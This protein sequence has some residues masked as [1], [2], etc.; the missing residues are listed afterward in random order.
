V[1]VFK[2]QMLFRFT[3]PSSTART[4]K[5]ARRLDKNLRVATHYRVGTIT[6]IV[7]PS[8]GKLIHAPSS[9]STFVRQI[10]GGLQ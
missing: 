10:D 3:R 8:I 1:T 7:S 9:T 5:R 4:Q 2:I 6:A